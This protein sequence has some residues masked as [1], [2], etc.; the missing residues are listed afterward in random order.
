MTFQDSQTC[1]QILEDGL[2]LGDVSVQLLPADER[3]CTIYIRDLPVEIDD[4]VVSSF[5]AD[6]GE[7]D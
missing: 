1:S 6:F 5:L 7:V 4:E 3:L 2:D